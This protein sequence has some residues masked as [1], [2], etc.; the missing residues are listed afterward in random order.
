MQRAGPGGWGGALSPSTDFGAVAPTFGRVGGFL[1]S[2]EQEMDQMLQ[3]PLLCKAMR[4][5]LQTAAVWS[6]YETRPGAS[7]VPRCAQSE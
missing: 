7:A 5:H 4:W 6:L 1:R 2:I 3:V